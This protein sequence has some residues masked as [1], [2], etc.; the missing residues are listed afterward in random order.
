MQTPQPNFSH[1]LSLSGTY[2]IF[3][4][5]E[6]SRAR[7]EHGYCTD[8]VAR[9]LLV[10][11]REASAVSEVEELATFSMGFLEQAQSFDGRFWNRRTAEGKWAGSSSSDDCWG[12]ALWALGTT[13][14]LSGDDELREIAMMLF[15]RGAQVRSPWARPMAFASFGAAEVLKVDSTNRSALRLVEATAMAVDRPDRNRYWR[16]SE[17]RLT[18]ANAALPEAMLSAGALLGDDR[19]IETGLRQLRW[20]L[21]IETPRGHLSVTPTGGRDS[22]SPLRMYDQQ[23]IEVAAMS[24]ACARAYQ[25]TGDGQWR[26]GHVLCH[27]WFMGRNDLGVVMFDPESGGGY[28]GLTAVGPNLNQGAESTIALL[29]TL[30]HARIF[31]RASW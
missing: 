7:V 29:T 17:E 8:D 13:M 24:E 21:E 18:Y 15:E 16:W 3:E 10:S 6:Y 19:L 4:H 2:G 28:D 9:A 1:L 23:P 30:Q 22:Q 11:V 5:A 14:A 20:L 31:E 27:E 26:I 25:M 12:R